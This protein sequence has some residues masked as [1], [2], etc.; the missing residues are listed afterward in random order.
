V[1]YKGLKRDNYGFSSLVLPSLFSRRGQGVVIAVCL[2]SPVVG[3]FV[4]HYKLLVFQV[5]DNTI[6]AGGQV[7]LII[8]IFE[9]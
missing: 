6:S 3:V 8:T 4:P 9:Q 1:G 5:Y 2:K 7:R